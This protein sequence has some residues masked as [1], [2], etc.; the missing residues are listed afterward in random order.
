MTTDQGALNDLSEGLAGA[1][2]T[3]AASTV[4]VAARRRIPASGIVWVAAGVVVTADHVIEQDEQI[5]LVLPDDSEVAA[6]L[7]GRDPRTDIAVL[8]AAGA[9]ALEPATP[10][11]EGA[12]R[13]GHL[14]LAVGRPGREG[15]QASMGVVSA[16]GGAGSTRRG[17]SRHRRSLEGFIRSDTTFY[18]GFSGGPLVD[19]AGRVLG[20]NTSRFRPGDGITIPSAVLGSVVETLLSGGRLTRAYLGVGSQTVQLPG[21][22]AAKLGG[23]ETG[24]LIISV[25][26]GTPADQGGLLMGDILVRVED[27]ALRHTADLQTSLGSERVGATV[28]IGV[29]RGGEPAEVSVTLGERE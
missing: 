23:Q 18:P 25:E 22:L 14:V 16:I 4:L 11:E 26:A 8:R 9:S 7:V 19:T 1:V 3:A 20:M 13:V 2:S 10:V 15:P 5:R 24:L 21:A 27:E 29:L 28:R 17:H 12:A 6:E